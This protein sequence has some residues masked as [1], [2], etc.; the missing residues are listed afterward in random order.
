MSGWHR[1]G[2]RRAAE[3]INTGRGLHPPAS[4]APLRLT[5][6]SAGRQAHGIHR[7]MKGSFQRRN[8]TPQAMLYLKGTQTRSQNTDKLS[9][10]QAA[11]VLLHFLQQAREG[12]DENPDDVYFQDLP[13]WKRE[14]F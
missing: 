6:L 9:V 7:T 10:D 14:Y 13:L 1:G 5:L 8:W 4:P 3:D 12:A 2:E 11:T